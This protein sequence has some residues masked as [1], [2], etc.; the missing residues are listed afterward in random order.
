MSKTN[1]TVLVAAYRDLPTAEADWHD[2]ETVAQEGLYVADAALV[3]KDARATRRSSS[4]SLTMVGG[5]EP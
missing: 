5:R 2:L 3:T 1:T 4:A